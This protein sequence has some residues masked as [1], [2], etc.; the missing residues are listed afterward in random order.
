[1]GILNLT[2]HLATQEQ[3]KAGV[4]ELDAETKAAI[5]E[6]LTFDEIPSKQEMESR[7]HDVAEIAA[8][9]DISDDDD[10]DGVYGNRAMIGGAP[11]FM[12]VLEAELK[13]RFIMPK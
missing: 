10:S 3:I 4:V 6:L 8:M 7:A 5:K 1:M 9:Y 11:F 12:S 2:Q 13:D